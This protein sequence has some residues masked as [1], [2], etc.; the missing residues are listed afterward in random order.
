[1]QVAK[2]VHVPAQRLLELG[3]SLCLG[4]EL[5]GEV[6]DLFPQL[7]ALRTLFGKLISLLG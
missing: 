4:A 6:G 2:L 5:G 7:H 1:M 3:M